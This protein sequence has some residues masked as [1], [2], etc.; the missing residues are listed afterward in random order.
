MTK[1]TEEMN[2][3][4]KRVRR[5]RKVKVEETP[6]VETPQ[7]EI[8]LVVPMVFPS[9]PVWVDSLKRT[10]DEMHR[11]DSE[12]EKSKRFRSWG[13]E[14]LMIQAALKSMPWIR[15]VHILLSGE[16]QRQA[17]MDKLGDKVSF[18]VQVAGGIITHLTDSPL[19]AGTKVQGNVDFAH[20]F[21]KQNREP[22]SKYSKFFGKSEGGLEGE[23]NTLLQQRVSLSL[24]RQPPHTHHKITSASSFCAVR[25]GGFFRWWFWAF[26]R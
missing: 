19:E 6:Q 18:D 8:D 11:F 9:D 23:G 10:R 17:W 12:D 16:T 1:K 13:L 7:Q 21:S 26:V 14:R 2:E 3:K 15:R 25:C 24:Q 20:R 22:N 4:P 5:V